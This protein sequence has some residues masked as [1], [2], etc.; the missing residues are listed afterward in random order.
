MVTVAGDLI[1]H[2]QA[3]LAR[4]ET[5]RSSPACTYIYINTCFG[6]SPI[7]PI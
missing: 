6:L 3:L 5:F 7:N 4:L 1:K 2:G